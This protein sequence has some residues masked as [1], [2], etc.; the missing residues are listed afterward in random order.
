MVITIDERNLVPEKRNDWLGRLRTLSERANEA[1]LK[2]QA[3]GMHA[4]KS[5]RANDPTR[6]TVCLIHGL[7]SSSAGFVHV[8]PVARSGGI[9]D[10][11][12]RLPVQPAPGRVVR[13][14]Y[15]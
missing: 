10:R 1:A 8:V 6:P 9:R 2:R 12:L 15:A 7:N 13:C 14:V 3:Y 4:L 11:R 5:F